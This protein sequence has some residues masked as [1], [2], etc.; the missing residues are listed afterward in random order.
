MATLEHRLLKV[1]EAQQMPIAQVLKEF[2][3]EGE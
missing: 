1:R 2:V 3:R